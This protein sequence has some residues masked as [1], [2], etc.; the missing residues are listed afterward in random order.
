[1]TCST[2]ARITRNKIELR[3][4]RVD[5]CEPCEQA[6]ETSAA[7]DR[8]ASASPGCSRCRAEPH[9]PVRRSRPADAGVLQP[10]QQC[11]QVHR[12]GGQITVDGGAPGRRGRRSR[13]A[14]PASASRREHAAAVFDMFTQLA[15]GTRPRRWRARYRPGADDAAWSSCTAERIDAYSAGR[16]RGCE[17]VV[18]LPI[19]AAQRPTED[20]ARRVR[21]QAAEPPAR[22]L[23]VVDDNA[24]AAQTL[25]HAVEPARSGGARGVHGEEA[26]RIV[27]D[28]QPDVA[29]L[30]IGLPDVSRL[31]AVP[32]HPRATVGRAA[33]ADRLHGLGSARGCR[34][35]PSTRG[36][37][38]TWSSRW[39]RAPCCAC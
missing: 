5:V 37:T 19:E 20:A 7:A 6:L 35:R 12:S 24:D 9:H 29:V 26:L 34:S 36:S 30:D 38:S 3:R 2:S 16:G 8:S 39:T 4:E 15:R 14:T 1:M 23:L 18:T 17:F 27:Q 13:C 11:R 28:W 21:R 32:P 22:R 10:A 33:A 25:S 31:R